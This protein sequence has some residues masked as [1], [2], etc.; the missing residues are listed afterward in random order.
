MELLNIVLP[1]FLVI[2]LG[3]GLRRRRFLTDA[4]TQVL[5][6]LV[7]Y[8]AGP[9]L[10]LRSAA[11]T[12]LAGGVILEVLLVAAGVSVVFAAA[13][14]LVCARCR[15][16]RRGVI[17]QGAHRSNMVFMGLPVVMNAYG[18]EAL[19][20]ASVL[21]G[22][23]VMLYNF[24]G[25]LV[26]TLPHRGRSAGAGAVWASSTARIVR[27]PLI[28]G[29]GAGIVLSATGVTLP[30]SVDQALDLI[31]RTALPMAL[32]AVGAGLDLGR[33]RSELGPALAVAAG[34]LIAYPA[35]VYLALR[36]LGIAGMELHVP[37]LILA[38]PTAVVSYIMAREMEGDERL[39]AAIVIGTTLASLGTT[40]AWLAY[41]HVR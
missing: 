25:V 38:A 14:Y 30:G 31:G 29:S 9:L 10:L 17:A 28:L 15:P 35:L 23:M 39:A 3:Y 2:G 32:I 33:L 1:V 12:E 34:K 18:E 8:V 36:A 21:I 41:F 24:L 37:V 6:R 5:S 27:N 19:G 11:H 22:F 20:L 40:V 26:L 7:F 4:E 13:V 16:A